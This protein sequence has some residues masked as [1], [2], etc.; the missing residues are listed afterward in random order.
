MFSEWIKRTIPRD[1]GA[2]VTQA[3]LSLKQSGLDYLLVYN[4]KSLPLFAQDIFGGML[5][6]VNPDLCPLVRGG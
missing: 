2:T 1:L 3:L 4:V 5:G 6:C